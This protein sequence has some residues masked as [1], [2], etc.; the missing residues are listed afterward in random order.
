MKNDQSG[1][2]Q[3]TENRYSYVLIDCKTDKVL[4]RI[5]STPSTI[6][7]LNHPKWMLTRQWQ[8]VREDQTS[9]RFPDD[10]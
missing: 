6:S 7:M 3:D 10:C 9:L 5:T 4:A 1:V 8:Y 2:P